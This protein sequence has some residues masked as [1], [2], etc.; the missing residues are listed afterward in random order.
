MRPDGGDIAYLWDMREQAKRLTDLLSN[1]DREAF[2]ADEG[3][4]LIAERRIEIIGQAASHVSPQLRSEHTEIPWR[5]IIGQRNILIHAYGEVIPARVWE[6]AHRDAPE[7]VRLL[8]TVIAE[9]EASH[10]R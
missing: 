8:D 9:M 7:L 4:R 3:L 1:T 6:S 5:Q 2:L 10:D